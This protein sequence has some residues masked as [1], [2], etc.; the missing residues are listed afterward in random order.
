V[1]IAL[2]LNKLRDGDVLERNGIVGV[3]CDHRVSNPIVMGGC[4]ESLEICKYCVID[5]DHIRIGVEIR[6]GFVAEIGSEYESIAAVGAGRCERCGCR[7]GYRASLRTV[8]GRSIGRRRRVCCDVARE[9]C[10]DELA[11]ASSVAASVALAASPEAL[12]VEP[13][14]RVSL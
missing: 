11:V 4:Q 7:L 1:K 9:T 3:G 5:L 13:T 14:A 6:N 8:A 12:D 10:V 2:V